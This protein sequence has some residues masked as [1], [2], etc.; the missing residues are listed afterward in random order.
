MEFSFHPERQAEEF[1][2]NNRLDIGQRARESKIGSHLQRERD[3]GLML[4]LIP[5]RPNQED[6]YCENMKTSRLKLVFYGIFLK[7]LCYMCSKIYRLILAC[8]LFPSHQ[9]QV[10]RLSTLAP[11]SSLWLHLHSWSICFSE[12]AEKLSV[13]C[14]RKEG[15]MD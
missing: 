7:F 14:L 4:S 6:S 2:S 8:G 5:Y 11:K 12:V 13:H 10:L 3:R 9:H 15:L 1:K